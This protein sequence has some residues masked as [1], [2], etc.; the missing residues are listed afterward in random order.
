MSKDI[1]DTQI[2]SRQRFPP[3]ADA[4][5]SVAQRE[6]VALYRASWRKS[7]ATSDGGLGG[8]LDAQL[9]CPGFARAFMTVS[10]YNRSGT[11]L[12]APVQELIILMIAVH[13]QCDFEWDSHIA[14]ALQA[15]LSLDTVRALGAGER[16]GDLTDELSVVYD[17][18]NELITRRR[19]SDGAFNGLKSHLGEEQLMEIVGIAGYY[20]ALSMILNTGE[21]V[22]PNPPRDLPTFRRNIAA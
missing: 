16:P 20:T 1:N 18:V 14:K 19:I 21:T 12:S 11:P 5:M 9:R 4:Q 13:Q 10:D 6:L 22:H 7:L 3:L 2:S 17:A 8:P 15:G